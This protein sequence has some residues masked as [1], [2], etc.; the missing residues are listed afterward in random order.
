MRLGFLPAL[1]SYAFCSGRQEEVGGS[2]G[3]QVSVALPSQVLETGDFYSLLDLP[4]RLF[5][6]FPNVPVYGDQWGILYAL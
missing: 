2:K 5:D 1:F 4:K 3:G 6:D